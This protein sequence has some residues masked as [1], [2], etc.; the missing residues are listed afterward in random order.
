MLTPLGQQLRH[1]REQ[2][3][4]S[5]LD[6]AHK[7]KI[8]AAKLRDLEE[9]IYTNF[10]SLTYAKSFLKAYAHYLGVDASSILEQ[11][12]PPPLGGE[13]SYRYLT[14]TLGT[15]LR[16][17]QTR[18]MATSRP[19]AAQRGSYVTMS[20]IGACV[21]LFGVS[22]LFSG[23]VFKMN[24]PSA[25][26]EE[27]VAKALPVIDPLADPGQVSWTTPTGT[28]AE[29]TQTSTNAPASAAEAPVVK[30]QPLDIPSDKVVSSSGEII[31]PLKAVPV[32]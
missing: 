11:I 18:P 22:V 9:D 20:V 2:R 32:E 5:L 7:T 17:R 4:L 6:V 16:P 21:L 28:G 30:A 3:G 15:W 31:T 13:N 14:R 12:Q 29:D 27:T 8:P 19:T 23:T 25:P 26:K 1:A 10:G 24:D